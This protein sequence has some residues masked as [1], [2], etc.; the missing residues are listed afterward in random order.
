MSLDNHLPIDNKLSP[1]NLSVSQLS[2]R[3]LSPVRISPG[4]MS[5]AE[6][7][8]PSN[9]VPAGDGSHSPAYSLSPTSVKFKRFGQR[10]VSSSRSHNHV[11][12]RSEILCSMFAPHLS[13]LKDN[14]GHNFMYFWLHQINC[15]SQLQRI[16]DLPGLRYYFSKLALFVYQCKLY[17]Y[18][19]GQRSDDRWRWHSSAI[20]HPIF[21]HLFM[22]VVHSCNFKPTMN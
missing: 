9:T 11:R 7:L 5:P 15:P 18:C 19:T 16:P 20:S 13:L 22:I 6:S 1:E 3:R 14:L 2:P 4:D 12:F 21:D 8:S 10:K 17:S